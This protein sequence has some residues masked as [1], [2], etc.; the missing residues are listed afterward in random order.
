ML[1]H[2][3]LLGSDAPLANVWLSA[4]FI[5]YKVKKKAILKAKLDDY[6]QMILNPQMPLTLKVNVDLKN[7]RGLLQIKPPKFFNFSAI[8]SVKIL[9]CNFSEKISDYRYFLQISIY[10]SFGVVRIFSRKIGYL[11]NECKQF[12]A[13]INMYRTKD[14]IDINVQIRRRKITL[15]VL[16]SDNAQM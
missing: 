4:H 15:K 16:R 7:F 6:I 9:G 1:Y 3:L 5:D 13:E 11:L 14:D 10:L 8:D 2:R 12:L